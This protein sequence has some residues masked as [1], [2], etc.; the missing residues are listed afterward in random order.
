M[1]AQELAALL[2]PLPE[3]H[4]V[5]TAEGEITAAN[6]PALRLLG[7]ESGTPP[8]PSL[9]ALVTDAADRVRE[10]LERW[11]RSGSMLPGRLTLRNT[12]ESCR[13]RGSALNLDAGG[14]HGRFLLVRFEPDEAR[15][16]RFT[17]LNR[18]I[19]DLTRET[20]ERM[21]AEEALRAGERRAAFLAEASRVLAT[22]LDYEET[23]RNVAR[24]AVPELADWCA[25]DLLA[26]DGSLVRVAVEH[27][28][29]ARV[30]LAHELQSRYPT[31]PDAPY[32]AAQAVRT[33]ESQLVPVIPD[34]LLES[35]AVD[36]EHLAMIRG[37]ALHSFI[38]VPVTT[39]HARLGALTLVY[40]ESARVYTEA[41]LAVLEDLGRRAGT[42]IESARLVQAMAEARDR[43]EEQAGELELQTEQL[44]MQATQLEE[45]A[46][47][48]QQQ[49]SEVEE[50]NAE[51]AR[52]NAGLHAA[53]Q[54]AE[55]ARE[56]AERAN[57]AKSQFLAVMSHELRT[58]MNA[59]MG[60]TD[61]LDA[62]I[63][64]PLNE[65]QKQ[66]L[67]RVRGGARHLLGL[68]DQVLSL[69]RIEA[70]REEV[71]LSAADLPG[72]VNDVTSMMEPLA[73]R[74]G[75]EL[76]VA[77]PGAP[78]RFVTDEGKVR[79]IL[80]N[81]VGNAIKF[82]EEGRVELEVESRNGNM[83]FHVRDTGQG[84]APDDIERVF[85]PFEQVDQS[86]TRRAEGTGLGL[87][88]SRQLARLLGGDVLAHSEPGK[89]STFTLKL[90]ANPEPDRES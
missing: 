30:Q 47:E 39:A 76:R 36:A 27:P 10:Q 86:I 48:L 62:E 33:G 60:F 37:L 9:E 11:S 28:D 43:I 52:S 19:E 25:V 53:R 41:D 32:G 22:S 17:A 16:S 46:H 77:L 57:Q 40:A 7:L 75:L 20:H 13:C 24:L 69:A 90:P 5:L 23:L 85:D 83:V 51:L 79:Q 54:Q 2:R 87:S 78:P 74:R 29:P 31:D 89:G 58:P 26:P 35:V 80:L 66:Q 84:I 56:E 71:R 55:S 81:L 73:T 4:V 88:V 67:G 82:T 18:T 63:S 64:G 61:L 49:L 38:V 59:I 8:A 12:G 15:S 3:P 50:L 72:L 34:G 42:A 65:V 1:T 6:A 44:Q 21:R 14:E 70:G 45:Q 68:I